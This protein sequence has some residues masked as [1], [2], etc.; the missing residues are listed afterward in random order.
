MP[1]MVVADSYY[2]VLPWSNF[3]F[4][5][6]ISLSIAGLMAWSFLRGTSAAALWLGTGMVILGVASELTGMMSAR[7]N[8]RAGVA[9]F[10][11]SLF[12]AG[13]CQL[14][15]AARAYFPSAV[16]PPVRQKLLVGLAYGLAIVGTLGI[17][18]VASRG[19][20]P[21]F[22]TDTGSTLLRRVV[23]G[24][25]VV[26]FFLAAVLIGGLYRSVRQAFLYWYAIGLVLLGVGLFGLLLLRDLNSVLAWTGRGSQYI[27]GL[28]LLW[29]VLSLM[30]EGRWQLPLERELHEAQTRY[31]VIFESMGEGFATGQMIYDAQGQAV[32][33]QLLEV[34]DAFERLTGLKRAAAIAGTVRQLVPDLE[35]EWIR[36]H[37]QVVETGLPRNDEIYNRFTDKTYAINSCRIA[38]GR[39]ASVFSD[40]TKRKQAEQALRERA[41]EIE[42]L[43]EVVPAAVW[44]SFDPQCQTII[45][46][47]RANE[48]YE[49]VPGEN[50]SATNLPG[51]RRFF[52]LAGRELGPSELPMQAAAAAN[53][54]VLDTELYVEL[55]SGKRIVILGSAAPLRDAAGS[56]RG[57][58]AAFLNIT[59]RKRAE[60]AVRERENELRRLNLELEQRVRERTAE[61]AQ[62]AAQLRALAGELTLSE[63]RERGRMA[64]I[65][66]DHLQQLLVGAK[67]RMI[68]LGNH[69]DFL[70]QQTIE[71]VGQLL[72]ESI[73]A[74]RSLTAELSPPILHEAGLNAG[75]E[76]LARW[77]RSKHGLSVELSMD[78]PVPLREDVKVLLFESVRELLFNVVKHSQTRSATVDLRRGARDLQVIVSDEGCGF[79][80]DSI[81]QVGD[82]AAGFG[83]F[84]IRERLDLMGGRL[85]V[86]SAAGKGCRCLLTVPLGGSSTEIPQPLASAGWPQET[87][88]QQR[89]THSA[90]AKIR[91]LLADDHVVMREG[92]AGLLEQATDIEIVGQAADGQEAVELADRLLPDVILMDISMPRLNGIEATRTIHKDHPEIRIIGLSMFDAADRAQAMRDAGAVNYVV[93]S[94]PPEDLFAAIREC[95]SIP[96]PTHAANTRITP[97]SGCGPDFR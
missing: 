82:A 50:V 52:S 3:L 61:L 58:I 80:V 71:E 40:I 51:V 73:Q 36:H 22:W 67:F 72:D 77:M 54:D 94:G 69:S 14:I 95:Q 42:R 70:V 76:W 55:P 86:D 48:F 30:R 64:R 44:V 28:Y 27:G 57:C 45:G 26:E 23:L 6:L 31:R 10:N 41:E 33:Y 37:A 11:I 13:L 60:E 79:N 39:F 93:K 34:N 66:H 46:N 89:M 63:Q 8:P 17:S 84:T 9:V 32:D 85:E 19:L 16:H 7:G 83:L 68:V 91:V 59:D 5:T 21:E 90:P 15:G 25:A 92:L 12:L 35:P 43:L 18:V 4:L 1:E 24:A 53:R 88:S 75:L 56:V 62:R 20:L 97:R 87:P 47:R 96:P 2:A 49:A 38:P 81:P 78:H 74:S 29:A 65:L